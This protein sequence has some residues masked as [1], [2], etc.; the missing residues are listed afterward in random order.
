MAFQVTDWNLTPNQRF[1]V[2][3]SDGGSQIQI[4]IY[5]T[6]ADMDASTNRV[7]SATVSFGTDVE[8][9][10]TP[11]STEPSS[12]EA[13][14]KFNTDLSYDLKATGADGDPTKKF[15]I[16]PFTDM[17][18]IEDALLVTEAMIQA[19]ATLEIN[20]GTHSKLSR[21]LQLDSHYPDL[22]EGDI[23]S[24]SSTKRGLASVRNRID[25]LTIKV[26]IDESKEVDFFDTLEVTEYV[27]IVR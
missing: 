14:A 6:Q 2:K 23:V 10:I 4:D 24:L 20:K 3:L 25:D 15:Q 19:R 18:P 7:A 8:V 13:L 1:F 27:D 16:G 26:V 17:P 12:G 21:T 5:N 22:V 9:I 11:D